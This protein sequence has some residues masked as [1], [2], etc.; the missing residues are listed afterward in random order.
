MSAGAAG[1]PLSVLVTGGAGFIGRWVVLRLLD[2]GHR[3]L[4]LDNLAAGSPAN[5]A[6]AQGRDGFMGLIEGDVTHPGAVAEALSRAPDLCLHLAASI[7]VQDS[8]DDPGET[9]RNDVQG[10]FVLLEAAR[11]RQTPVLFMSTC[12]VYAA[13]DDPIDEAHPTKPASPYAACKLAGEALTLSYWHAYG[14]PTCV[15]RPFNTYG[16]FQRAD[17]EG[18]V[19]AIFAKRALAGLPLEVFGSGVQTRDLLYV[20]DCAEFVVR[21][22][23]SGEAWGQIVNAGT[24]RDIPIG[25]L[26]HLMAGDDGRVTFVPHIHPQSEIYRLR[27]DSHR[28]GDLFGWQAQVDLEE[29]IERTKAWVGSAGGA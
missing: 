6:E 12:M 17:G 10:T 8:I 5:L 4:A 19:V 21:A 3:V 9:F 13:G 28:A 24:G 7:N 22:A 20:E 29:G 25:D 23:L 15:V 1:K 18:G 11:A 16:P 26:A 27:C 14:L 2:Q